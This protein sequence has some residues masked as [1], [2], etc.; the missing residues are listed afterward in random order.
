MRPRNRTF[1]SLL[2]LT[3]KVTN[4]KKINFHFLELFVD[5]NFRW[6]EVPPVPDLDRGLQNLVRKTP[7]RQRRRQ[8][9]FSIFKNI[10]LSIFS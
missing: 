5:A 3:T 2:I 8:F 9:Q 1:S 6:P 7:Q 10:F 4:F